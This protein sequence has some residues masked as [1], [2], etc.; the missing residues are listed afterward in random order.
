VVTLM[1]KADPHEALQNV[2]GALMPNGDAAYQCANN[3]Q[4]RCR[5][6]DIAYIPVSID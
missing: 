2:A 4:S 1:P 3:D 5:P 6:Q